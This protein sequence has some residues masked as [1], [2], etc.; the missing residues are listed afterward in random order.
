LTDEWCTS[1]EKCGGIEDSGATWHAQLCNTLQCM[2]YKSSPAH[3]DVWSCPATKHD[4]FKYYGY[5]LVYVD[6][7]LVLSHD[8]R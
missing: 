4:G 7:I 2:D 6:G 5:L 1:L 3:P 8:P